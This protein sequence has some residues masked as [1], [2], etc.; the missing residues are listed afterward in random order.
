METEVV[1]TKITRSYDVF[2]ESGQRR[3]SMGIGVFL[4]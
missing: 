1:N 2:P 3:E 4:T